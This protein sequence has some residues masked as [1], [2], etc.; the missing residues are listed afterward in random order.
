M[1]IDLLGTGVEI[2]VEMGEASSFLTFSEENMT[3]SLKSD[4]IVIDAENIGSYP[5]KITLT[6]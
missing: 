1:V 6:T 2:L 3:F 4:L 5:I